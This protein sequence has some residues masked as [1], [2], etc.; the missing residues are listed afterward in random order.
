MNLLNI[1][2]SFSK[3]FVYFRLCLSRWKNQTLAISAGAKDF[4]GSLGFHKVMRMF[5]IGL[6]YRKWRDFLFLELS[7][8]YRQ[9]CL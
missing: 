9:N 2:V 8:S 7:K 1:G 6:Y 4:E 3:E 5:S